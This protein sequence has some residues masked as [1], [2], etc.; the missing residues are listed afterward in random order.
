M[1]K[2]IKRYEPTVMFRVVNTENLFFCGNCKQ[3]IQQH[4][5]Y[6]AYCGK[7]IDWK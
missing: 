1:K 6:C 5:G 2:K 3:E 7:G 4:W